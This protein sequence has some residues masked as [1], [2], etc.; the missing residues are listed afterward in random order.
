M[1]AAPFDS[2]D[3]FALRRAADLAR[4]GRG[5][6][7]PNPLVGAVLYRGEHH[8]AEGFH[9]AYGDRHAEVEVL[10]QVSS[11]PEGASL[12]VTLEPCSTHGKQPPC[13]EAVI[14]A[15][16]RRVVI[17]ELDP[18]E[19]HHGRGVSMLRSQGIHVEVAPEGLMPDELLR[20]F[21]THLERSRPYVLLKWATTLDG[22]WGAVQPRE[23]RWISS[24]ESRREVHRLRRHVDGILVGA[25]TLR[26][27]D[28][29]L[30]ARPPGNVPLRRMVLAGQS[31]L[32]PS[33]RLFRSLEEGEV[34]VITPEQQSVP[35]GVR[36]EILDVRRLADEV[37]PRLRK[38]GIHRLLVEGG[39]QVAA[40]FLNE[41]AVDRAWVFVAPK[42]LQGTTVDGPRLG[43]TEST[44]SAELRPHV[45][46]VRSSGCDAW[47]KLSFG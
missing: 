23:E 44:L 2:A 18:S 32:D 25:G 46:E 19:P 45:E 14:R 9:R 33:A 28:P 21:R 6:V 15:G 22:A 11:I 42:V 39:P 36:Q 40:S 13:V 38:Q 41:A 43:A 26:S 27:D 29:L 12:A 16:V 7:E 30:T 34:W 10:E 3:R 47:F 35:S 4:H 5:E 24:P 17:G 1:S 8:L 20:E 31:G 37:L